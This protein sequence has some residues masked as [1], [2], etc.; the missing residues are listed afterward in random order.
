MAMTEEEKEEIRKEL[1]KPVTMIAMCAEAWNEFIDNMTGSEAERAMVASINDSV[2]RVAYMFEVLDLQVSVTLLY[3]MSMGAA[4]QDAMRQAALSTNP[5]A[6]LAYQGLVSMVPMMSVPL[7][8]L[9]VGCMAARIE[10]G[11]I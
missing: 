5:F 3:G 1:V 10:A 9:M 6:E 4:G 7:T 2:D 11:T 8:Q